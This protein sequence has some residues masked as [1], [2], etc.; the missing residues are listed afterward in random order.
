MSHLRCCVT[1]GEAHKGSQQKLDARLHRELLPG[2]VIRLQ[3]DLLAGRGVLLDVVGAAGDNAE[4]HDLVLHRVPEL[5]ALY[6]VAEGDPGLQPRLV[7]TAVP[8][9][10]PI[11]DLDIQS[12]Q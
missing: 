1:R 10:E 12:K 4:A 6:P 8:L 7:L 5:V 9:V 3:H 2:R 11:I